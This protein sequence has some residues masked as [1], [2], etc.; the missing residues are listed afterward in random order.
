[1]YVHAAQEPTQHV[2]VAS[3]SH[4]TGTKSGVGGRQRARWS[5]SRS[6]ATIQQAC[7]SAARSDVSSACARRRPFWIAQGSPGI[8]GPCDRRFRATLGID[9]LSEQAMCPPLGY[10]RLRKDAPPLHL[11]RW[12][13][14]RMHTG[15][16]DK[17]PPL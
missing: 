3:Q 13:L 4:S 17:Y 14:E 12:P 1:M 10:M 11:G 9:V 5:P 16:P 6:H 8:G 2:A 7:R 15:H